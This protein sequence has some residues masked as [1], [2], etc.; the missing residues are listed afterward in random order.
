MSMTRIL[1][2]CSNNA[3]S[4]PMAEAL[5]RHLAGDRIEASSAGIRP[6]EIRPEVFSALEKL[7]VSTRGLCSK[8]LEQVADR[9]FDL[10]VSLDHQAHLAANAIPAARHIT[11]NFDEP[12]DRDLTL[13]TR[14][15]HEI[16]ERIKLLVLIQ[17]RQQ[18]SLW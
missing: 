11:W 9:Y 14:T 2:L 15:L 6:G 1:F 10:V 16:Y 7:G 5:L 12:E 18:K 13:L 17:D 3:G 8:Q 4:S